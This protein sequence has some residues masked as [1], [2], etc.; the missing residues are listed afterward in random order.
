MPQEIHL[1]EVENEGLKTI[2]V[3]KL[4]LEARLEAWLEADVS[5]AG[6]D[7]LVIGK[8]VETA[9]GGFVDL[10]CFD[11]NADLV[12]LELKREKTPREVTAQ[13]LDYASWV[14]G[15][16][17]EEIHAIAAAYLRGRGPLG[18]AFRNQFDENLPDVVNEG[19][20]M[21]IVAS[22]IDDSTERIVRYLSEEHGVSINVVT[23]QYFRLDDDR[24][25]L[26]RVFLLEPE[27][28]AQRARTRGG[29]KRRARLTI[30]QLEALAA[31]N[32]VGD[33]YRYAVEVFET[34]FPK[35]STSRT[36][37]RFKGP[38][39]GTNKVMFNLIP[40]ESSADS[41]VRYQVYSHRLAQHFGVEEPH[42]KSALPDDAE[43]F[44]YY[45]GAENEYRGYTGFFRDMG[46]VDRFIAA[47]R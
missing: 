9:F 17:S 4:D 38:W 2:D 16:S 22:R 31:E 47:L 42:V 11:P 30:E 21:I 34:V 12:V 29:S 6:E 24:K 20:R 18:D 5:I 46:E 32:G 25:V 37:L 35:K 14:R 45:A 15:L 43:D 40:G 8:Q 33:L 36:F 26:G 7:L 19:H 1:W 39:K 28:V 13:V 10:L 41:G 3:G 23:F 44:E 27:H